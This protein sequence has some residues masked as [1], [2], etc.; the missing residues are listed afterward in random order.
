MSEE[1]FNWTTLDV[2][3]ATL[4]LGVS[5]GKGLTTA[6]AERRRSVHGANRLEERAPKSRWRLFLDQFR[7]FIIAILMAAVA[8][9]ALVG[10]YVDSLVILSI[11]LVNG[12]LGYIQEVRARDSIAALK[13]MTRLKARVVRDGREQKV[14]SADLVPGDV[15]LLETG[16]KVPADARVVESVNLA[17][18]ESSMTGESVPVSKSSGA[19]DSGV[20]MAEQVNMVFSGAIVSSGR[21]RALVVRTGMQSRLGRIAAMIQE[22]DEEPTPLQKRLNQL[23]RWLGI[24]VLAICA[25]TFLLAFF[26]DPGIWRS[27]TGE[28]PILAAGARIKEIFMTAVALA[29][30]AVP[31]GLAA[32]VTVALALGVQRMVRRNALIRRLPSVETLGSTTVICTDKTGT[33]TRNQMTVRRL[34]V[35]GR[36]IEVTGDGYSTRGG[37]LH[38]GDEVNPTELN[39]L[40]TIGAL[41]NDAAL[42][43]EGII[44]DPT[45]AALIVV[46][47]K[48]GLQKA[49][50]ELR[51][52]R[53]AE[54]AFDSRRKRMTTVHRMDGRRVMLV[55]G[56]PD[57]LLSHCTHMRCPGGTR[58]IKDEDRERILAANA[59]FAGQALRVLGFACGELPPGAE[60]REEGLE[61]IGLQAM[62]DPPR[63][64]ARL[65]VERCREA[66]IR[67]VMI[68]GDQASTAG[69]VAAELGIPGE[70]VS[71]KE[72]DAMA[73]LETRVDE[74]G[75]Y[76]RV[77]PEHKMR[78]VRALRNRGHVV[79]M[80]G[81]GVNDGPALKA[82]DIGIAMGITGTD[83]AKEASDMILTDDNFASIVD[84]VE[85]G[86]GLND[87]IGKFVNYLLSSNLGE[88]LVIFV[89]MLIGFSTATGPLLPLTAVQLL[90]LNIVTDGLPALALGVDPLDR[91]IMSRSPRPP[92]RAVLTPGMLVS[93]AMTGILLCVFTLILFARALDRG[94]AAAQTVAF[95]ALV[96][97]QIIR[98]YMVRFQ[99][100][101]RF[102]SNPWLWMAIG[103]SLLLQLFAVYLAPLTVG[104][105]FGTVPLAVS[106]WIEILLA[107]GIM[108]I[109]GVGSGRLI[110]RLKSV[111]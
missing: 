72:L 62:M 108:L 49:E 92:G 9:S 11:L 58:I 37:F 60:P 41:N 91:R 3:A 96:V 47:A 35:D 74:I 48:A 24:A 61:F 93:I 75:V 82:A 22:S 44:G 64:S 40:L 36:E 27:L 89:A 90:W 55:K 45:E 34:W 95:S 100:R 30:A 71:G 28:A 31:E 21:G 80:T 16:D 56:A 33:L 109:L 14:D 8:L 86:R 66:G 73:D 57:V 4:R 69:A 7:S 68:T 39:D 19:I 78:I 88:V 46:A 13:R 111:L 76:A 99:Y 42:D 32:V 6:E 105:L 38:Q 2:N 52:P 103:V 83:V 97:F 77:N 43:G 104:N 15:I 51:Y 5:P 10:E 25:I 87:N 50:L 54:I 98:V 59:D 107:G 23:G 65:A 106:D 20:V 26:R 79:A 67:V 53:E 18:D 102:F 1:S 29:V 85:E 17:C 63:R 12:L 110:R 94:G 84:A 81:D 101:V 70:A